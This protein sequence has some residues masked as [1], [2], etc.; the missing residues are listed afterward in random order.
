MKK[1]GMY[2]KKQGLFKLFRFKS[3][4]SSIAVAFSC[5]IVINI[6]VMSI[7]SY[8]IVE[9]T[10][11]R[12]SR[13]YSYQLIEQVNTNIESYITYMENISQMVLENYDVREYLGYYDTS[14]NISD[15]TLEQRISGYFRSIINARSDISSIM[16]FGANGKFISN[17]RYIRL[18]KSNNPEDQDWYKKAIEAGGKPVISSSHVQNVI[19]NEYR[20]VVTLSRELSIN[21]GENSLGVFLVDLNYS[22]INNMCNKI[23]LGEKGYIFIIDRNG[24][25]VYHPQQQLIY[26]N[27][28]TE[29]IDQVLKS[30]DSNFIAGEGK[31]R[32]MYTIK[33]SANTGWKIIGVNYVDELVSNKKDIQRSFLMGGLGF[34]VITILL[35]VFISSRISR[36]VKTLEASMKKVE[37]GNFDIKV[38]IENSNE[39]GELSKTFNIMIEKIKELMLQNNKEQE[40]KRKNELKALQAQINPHFLYNTL[41]SI[42][43]MAESKKS[44]EVVLMTSALAKLFRTSISKGEEVISINNE[45]EHIKNYLIIQ[46]I[47]YKNK[48]DFEIDVDDEI[49]HNKVLKIILQPLV[50]NSIYH[51]IKNKD[52]IGIIT[53]KGRRIQDKILLQVIDNGTGM[54][55]AEIDKVFN[56]KGRQSGSGIGVY[57]VNQ[58]IKLYYGDEY[59]LGYESEI[60]K[61]TIVSVWLPVID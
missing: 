22:V 4:Q 36:P 59:G 60:D 5:L 30:T 18:N 27:T 42:V 7:L 31:E 26:S 47:R 25:I 9:D 1:T 43:W 55:P 37:K 32:K 52:G 39:I 21:N 20:W 61:G 58:R 35:S 44:E 53:I 6:F 14:T 40:L 34:F 16:V 19:E 24:N 33:E 54:T 12:N 46:K 48:L 28:K 15:E 49:L 13:D 2:P 45:I 41:D 38:N 10:V 17:R 23:E 51:G 3:I 57:N 29:M 8:N 56:K 50:E 11:R